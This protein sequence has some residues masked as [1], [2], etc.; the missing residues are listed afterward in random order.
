MS[1]ETYQGPLEVRKGKKQQVN[2]LLLSWRFSIDKPEEN[3]VRR[4]GT[5]VRREK[6]HILYSGQNSAGWG[7]FLAGGTIHFERIVT[8]LP[9][10][11][12]NIGDV[13]VELGGKKSLVQRLLGATQNYSYV[14]KTTGGG[15]NTKKKKPY[16]RQMGRCCYKQ[17]NKRRESVLL[18]VE[19]NSG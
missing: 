11:K 13:A 4:G 5:K 6:E 19:N 15:K 7:E 16:T 14:G 9:K 18:L 2:A 12:D 10:G 17:I 8:D 3:C 1:A